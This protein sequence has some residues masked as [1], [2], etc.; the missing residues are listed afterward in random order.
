MDRV[1]VLFIVGLF[2]QHTIVDDSIT[3]FPLQ[4]H[5]RNRSTIDSM[6]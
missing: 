1:H 3:F 6:V 5:V 2:E 4:C